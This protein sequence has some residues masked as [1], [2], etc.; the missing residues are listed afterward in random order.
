MKSTMLTCIQ[1]DD[2]FEFSVQEQE[3]FDRLGFDAPQRCPKCRKHKFKASDV[4]EGKR[5]KEKRKPNR[6]SNYEFE[7]NFY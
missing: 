1:C 3:K 7:D 6:S 5:F 4:P 2:V